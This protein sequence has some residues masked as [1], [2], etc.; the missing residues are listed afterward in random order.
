MLLIGIQRLRNSAIVPAL[1][2]STFMGC[3]AYW[4]NSQIEMFGRVAKNDL[5][6]FVTSFP[7]ELSTSGGEFAYARKQVISASRKT[8]TQM[9]L[10]AREFR[11]VIKDQGFRRVVLGIRPSGNITLALLCGGACF[12]LVYYRVIRKPNSAHPRLKVF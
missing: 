11:S 2:A 4:F 10:A 9:L 12:F 7:R 3:A 6:S 1:I 5:R 8:G